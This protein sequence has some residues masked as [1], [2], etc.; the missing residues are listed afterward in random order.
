MVNFVL[1]ICSELVGD[2]E[3]FRKMFMLGGRSPPK[4]SGS[5]EA[6]IPTAPPGVLPPGPGYFWIE[7]PKPTGYR[8]LLVSVSESGSQN[9][10]SLQFTTNAV[11]KIYH[12]SKA[13]KNS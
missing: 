6:L 3:E 13:K 1:N 8:V 4:S 2:F 5:W 9:S 10:V 11:Y 12:N 7:F